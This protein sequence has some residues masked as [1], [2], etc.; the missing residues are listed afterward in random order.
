MKPTHIMPYIVVVVYDPTTQ[1]KTHYSFRT[2]R[3]ANQFKEG[4]QIGT[5]FEVGMFISIEK[6]KGKTK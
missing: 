3:Q 4:T 1:Q 2:E 5:N 6:A